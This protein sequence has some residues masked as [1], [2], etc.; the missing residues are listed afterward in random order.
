MKL[1]PINGAGK[2][3][4]MSTDGVASHLRR[5]RKGGER[6]ERMGLPML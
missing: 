3:G 5:E 1:E 4:L 6:V 2:Y